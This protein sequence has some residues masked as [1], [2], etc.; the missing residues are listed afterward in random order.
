MIALAHAHKGNQAR[1]TQNIDAR[2]YELGSATSGIR[3]HGFQLFL[4][5]FLHPHAAGVKREFFRFDL[6]AAMKHCWDFRLH[7][8]VGARNDL[9]NSKDLLMLRHDWI[10]TQK[11][12]GSDTIIY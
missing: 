12:N 11:P 4:S 8:R 1:I 7:G 5:D 10:L 3:I 2:I 6:L 9:P